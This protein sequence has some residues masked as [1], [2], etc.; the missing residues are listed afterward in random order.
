MGTIGIAC[1]ASGCSS[2]RPEVSLPTA[3][4]PAAEVERPVTEPADSIATPRPTAMVSGDIRFARRGGPAVDIGETVVYLRR[5]GTAQGTRSSSTV[6]VTSETE[7][8]APPLTVARPRQGIVLANEGPLVHRIFTSELE[9][10]AFELA[11]GA[12]SDRFSVGGRGP[13]R[14]YCSLHSDETFVIYV[15]DA[16]HVAVLNDSLEFEFDGVEPG[17]Y[18]LAIWSERVSGPIREVS[19]DGFTRL[20]EPIWLFADLIDP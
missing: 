9:D 13:V 19:V 15:E 8:F 4:P 7:E 14:F 1:L 5:R 18:T 16:P 20:R 6:R 17:R 2:D 11:P 12:R 10:V 3:R